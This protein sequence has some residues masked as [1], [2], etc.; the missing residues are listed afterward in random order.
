MTRL[1]A[2]ACLII[3]GLLA[4][5]YGYATASNELYGLLR[6]IGWGAVA[7]VGGCIPAWVFHHIDAKSYGRALVT[8]IGGLV[9]FS[10]TMYGSVGGITGSGDRVSAERSKAIAG[11]ADD[12]SELDRVKTSLARLPAHRPIGTVEADIAAAKGSK[13]YRSSEGCMPDRIT[14]GATREACEV[15][16]K[17]EGELET[18]KAASKLETDAERIRARLAKGPATQAADPGAAALALIVNMPAD[19]VAAWSALL[20]A[21][22]LEI[23]GMIAMMRAE[24]THV[25]PEGELARPES[26]RSLAVDAPVAVPRADNVLAMTSAKGPALPAKIGDVDRFMLEGVARAGKSAKVSWAELYVRYRAW[27]ESK[28]SVPVDA[29]AFGAKLDEPRNELGLRVRTRGN[30]VYFLELELAS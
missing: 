10:V 21:L 23:A 2:W 6:A 24:S 29:K 25:A 16:R 15:F 8:G 3:S 9:C 18:A 26:K 11:A 7:V 17:L 22:A 19:R 28:R 12:R 13:P 1:I 20:G 5:T 14:L 4:A 27:C 30:D